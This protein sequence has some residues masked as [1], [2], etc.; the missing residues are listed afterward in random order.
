MTIGPYG[1][2]TLPPYLSNDDTI[3]QGVLDVR[4]S[5]FAVASLPVGKHSSV[6]TVPFC[7]QL[8]SFIS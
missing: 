5:Y 4:E 1:N 3:V 6:D 8:C 7:E 2:L